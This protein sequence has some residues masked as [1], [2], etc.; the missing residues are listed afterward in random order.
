MDKKSIIKIL[1]Q[2][3]V[4]LKDISEAFNASG[5]IHDIQI[6]MALS[7]SNDIYN[8]FRLLKDTNDNIEYKNL[9]PHDAEKKVQ[10]SKPEPKINTIEEIAQ[11][12]P[13]VSTEA[14]SL[15]QESVKN[16]EINTESV[17][18]ASVEA[19]EVSTNNDK[20][21]NDATSNSSELHNDTI[22]TTTEVETNI[23]EEDEPQPI[24]DL[25]P[26]LPKETTP[27][28]VVG[29]AEETID[30][31]IPKSQENPK[32]NKAKKSS[33]LAD[34]FT[35]QKLSLNDMLSSFKK[36]KNLAASLKD[37]PVTNL[38]NAVKLNDRIWYV[39][40]LFNSDNDKYN[41]TIDHVNNLSNLD[42]ALSY[43]FENFEWD[44]NKKSTI[45]FIELIYLRFLSK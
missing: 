23:I 25:T 39:K 2:E 44:Q 18:E 42:E 14:H 9:G 30:E 31:V 32:Q 10:A 17:Q 34:Q 19:D 37:R 36:D 29:A 13:P 16:D 1:N 27:E 38:K 40:E 43:I 33:I 3:L 21:K 20:S 6:E 45:N 11:E 7:K 41:E 26:E 5:P 15:D 24:E 22:A 12:T 4:T 35:E 28:P 8:L